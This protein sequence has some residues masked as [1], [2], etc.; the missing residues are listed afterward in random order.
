MDV[1]YNKT[2]YLFEE[3]QDILGEDQWQWLET[4]LK[5]NNET[6]TFI[7]SGTQILPF[8]RIISEAWYQTSRK[9]LFD[10]IGN[11][12]KSGVIFLSGDIHVAQI[13]KTFCILPSKKF[14]F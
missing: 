2:G 9:R 14:N 6:F 7:G 10:L 1:R 3:K 4:V 12:N 8:D 5:D 11:L 13:L